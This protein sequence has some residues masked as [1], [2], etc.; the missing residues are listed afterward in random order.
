MRHAECEARRTTIEPDTAQELAMLVDTGIQV[1]FL[2]LQG[3]GMLTVG[4]LRCEEEERSIRLCHDAGSILVQGEVSLYTAK[5]QC[6]SGG[7]GAY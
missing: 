4:Y 3:S 2:L 1:V 7:G 6:K 5:F